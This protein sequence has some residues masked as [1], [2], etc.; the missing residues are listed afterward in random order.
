M[1]FQTGTVLNRSEREVKKQVKKIAATIV[2]ALV[3]VSMFGAI[4]PVLAARP[5]ISYS[6]IVKS[7]DGTPYVGLYVRFSLSANDGTGADDGWHLTNAEG[8]ATIN[9][10]TTR[11]KTMVVGYNSLYMYVFPGIDTYSDTTLYDGRATTK[12]IIVILPA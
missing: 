3:V 7:S 9:V 4:A 10:G 12:T 2:P 5:A 6:I 1:R 11:Y 8:Q